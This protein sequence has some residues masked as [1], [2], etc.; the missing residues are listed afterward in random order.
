MTKADL[1][2][3]SKY[4][5]Q[6]STW[7]HKAYN[8]PESFTETETVY[9]QAKSRGMD[10]VTL[11]DHDDIR[12]SLELVKNHPDD[13][14]ISCEVTTFFPEDGCKAHVLVYGIDESQYR[15]LMAIAK[16]IYL[17]RDYIAEQKIAY[18]V[19]HAT[20]DQD[21]RLGFEHI[22]KLVLLFDVF[23][24]VNG[25]SGALNNTLLDNYLK[26]LNK[27]MFEQLRAKHGLKPIST[28]SWIKGFTGGSDDH[29]GILIGS[30]YT[31]CRAQSV[32][33]YINAIRDKSSTAGGLHGSF[34]SFATG[35]IKH[36]HD[37]R[38]NS[39]SKYSNTKM[40]DFLELFF[41]DKEGNLVK[42]FKKSQSLRY[43]KK[44]NTKTHKALAALLQQ[45][46]ADLHT[47]MS[48]KIPQTYQLITD[49][50][51][52]MFCAV[53]EAFSKHL[54]SGDIFK[55][56]NRLVSLFPMSLLVIPFLG[57]M[58]HQ[59]LKGDIKRQLIVGANRNSQGMYADKAL[60]FTDTID[61][62]N[63]VSVSLR[64]IASFSATHGYN[65]KLVTCVN[66]DTLSSPLP[67][68]T[69]NFTPIIDITAPGYDT[70]KIGFPSLLKVMHQFINEQPDQ[71]IIS[72]PGPLGMAALLCAKIMDVPVKTIYHTD[73]AEQ[74]M[75]ISNE[76]SLARGVDFAVNLFYKQSDQVFVPSQFYIDKLSRT[77]LNQE[78]MS[79]FPRGI[80]LQL[81]SPEKD[82]DKQRLSHPLIRRHQLHGSFTLL[83]AGRISEDKNLS[84]LT[85]IIKRANKERPGTYNLVV[86]GDGPD[87]SRLKTNLAHQSNILFTGRLSSESLVEWYR[88]VDLLVFPSHTD[89]FGMV[90]LEAQA[91]GLPCL[92]TATGG[93]KEIILPNITGQIIHQDNSA[94]WLAMIEHYRVI[95]VSQPE[96]WNALSK[97]CSQH[98]H[99]QSSWQ[100]V[101]DDVL[102][103]NCRLS[104][105]INISESNFID[106]FDSAA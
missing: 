33:Q 36:V 17:L 18:S 32:S 80:D 34:E 92:V 68:G 46:Q 14:F 21:G 65:L 66:P 7:G 75:R 5:D 84:L 77:G 3:H 81:Y 63:G 64:Q 60:W 16:N 9:W 10:F 53:I 59:A 102:G 28:T 31:E 44:K 23:E 6:P 24:V 95:K 98:V 69:L 67:T 91:C 50:H 73:F 52:E 12:G 86:A 35:I 51:D 13:C 54:P 43:L 27:T 71:V 79:I 26:N 15:Q 106:E 87:L 38:A 42:R 62:L 78:R 105:R 37:Y 96:S 70:Q 61:D 45:V 39:G 57:A 94:D 72:T 58:R 47:D 22:E 1:H 19:A 4:S 8:S 25:A 97:L 85:E 88:S 100:R 29:C 83:F 101:F 48:D 30:A 49:L 2:V 90:V 104:E 20:H 40:S 82:S 89:T 99:T 41:D 11:T 103:D 93:P 74:V 56:F 55:G 76:P